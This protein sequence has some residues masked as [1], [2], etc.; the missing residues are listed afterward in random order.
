MKELVSNRRV[1]ILAVAVVL[2]ILWAIFMVPGGRPWTG[3]V[4]VGAL[5][6]LLVSSVL[7]LL[8]AKPPT[9]LAAVIQG[10]EDEPRRGDRIQ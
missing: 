1:S 10:V 6:F 4:W 9:S 5:A 7:L 8:A 3:V 2:S